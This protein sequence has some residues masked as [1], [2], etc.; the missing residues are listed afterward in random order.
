VHAVHA[1]DTGN[2]IGYG[3]HGWLLKKVMGYER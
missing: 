3:F 1:A 2:G